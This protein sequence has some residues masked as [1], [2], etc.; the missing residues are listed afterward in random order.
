MTRLMTFTQQ[1]T[2]LTDRI[3]KCKEKLIDDDRVNSCHAI[4]QRSIDR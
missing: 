3:D 2:L 1:L 4:I